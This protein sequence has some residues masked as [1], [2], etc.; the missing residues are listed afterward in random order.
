MDTMNK[1]PLREEIPAEDK[2]QL[3]DLYASDA[4]WEQALAVFEKAG[5]ELAGYAGRLAES[6]DVLCEYLSK[7]EA[8]NEDGSLLANYCM[9]KSD[10][11]T[12]DPAYQAMKGKFISSVIGL[13]AATSFETPEIM[14]IEDAVLDGFY[15]ACPELT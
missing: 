8:V 3:E 12:R 2:W 14:A 7:M 1:I 5:E 13:S 4:A 15:A 6:A 11:D 10:E 9:R